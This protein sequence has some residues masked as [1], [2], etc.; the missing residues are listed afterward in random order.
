MWLHNSQ[1]LA[2]VMVV[3]MEPQC[4][5]DSGGTQG[6]HCTFEQGQ[7]VTVAPLQR[8]GAAGTNSE[9][10]TNNE[11]GTN[12]ASAQWLVFCCC[13]SVACGRH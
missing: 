6:F 1:S 3:L 8:A 5:G 7:L 4:A 10:G 9:A 2:W 11:A 12:G 13:V